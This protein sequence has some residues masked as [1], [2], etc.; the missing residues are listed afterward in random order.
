MQGKRDPHYIRNAVT[1]TAMAI[2]LSGCLMGEEKAKS[3]EEVPQNN[4]ITGSVGDGPIAG[5]TIKV[6][7]ND[8]GL[9]TE[10]LSD[11]IGAHPHG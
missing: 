1:M 7:R 4:R 11:E 8:D 3:D 6:R 2:V 10:F 5:A 9:V